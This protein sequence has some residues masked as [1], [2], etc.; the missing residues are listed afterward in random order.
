MTV[1][2]SGNGILHPYNQR[3]NDTEMEERLGRGCPSR[4]T[5]DAHRAL[6]PPQQKPW[7]LCRRNNFVFES[8]LI[9]SKKCGQKWPGRPCQLRVSLLR[10][11]QPTN[12]FLGVAIRLTSGP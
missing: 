4:S 1:R 3:G 7:T 10:A 2:G 8:S 11:V 12:R 9:R 6:Q 5:R